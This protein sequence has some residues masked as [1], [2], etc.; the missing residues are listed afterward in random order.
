MSNPAPTAMIPFDE[1]IEH[2]R[3]RHQRALAVIAVYDPDGSD[4]SLVLRRWIEIA[5]S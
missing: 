4:L 3:R 1:M 5:R 2:L